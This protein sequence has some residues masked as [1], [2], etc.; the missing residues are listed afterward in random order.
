MTGE[1]MTHLIRQM[2]Y[3]ALELAAPFLLL[4]LFIGLIISLLQSITQMHEMTLAF[5]PKMFA[6]SFALVILF[7]WMLKI[8]TKFTNNLLIYQW[9]KITSSI[10]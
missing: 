4:S 1:Q 5:V 6:I 9:E 8:L 3:I 2:L 7:P 10:C